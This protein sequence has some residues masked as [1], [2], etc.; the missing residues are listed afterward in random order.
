MEILV[1][2]YSRHGSTARLAE[3]I[4]RGVNSVEGCEASLRTVPPVSPQ[5]E[6]SLPEVPDEGAPYVTNEDL[7]TC[8]GLILGSPTRFGNMAAPLKHFIDG[9]S[10]EW[11]SGALTGKPAAVFTSTSSL[12]GGQE[13]TLLTMALPLIHHGMLFV[14]VPYSEAALTQTR[15]G[16][17]PYGPSHLATDQHAVQPSE[18][19]TAIARALGARV[20][21]IAARL[22][23]K[24]T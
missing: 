24:E 4:A 15:T 23:G 19:E 17:T 14:G 8:A 6:Q 11:L 21:R 9:T 7:T 2:Y 3:Q 5:T 22:H 1:L 10:A 16:G 18:H 12:H 20:A 13:T